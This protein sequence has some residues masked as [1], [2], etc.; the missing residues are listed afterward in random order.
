MLLEYWD[1]RNNETCLTHTILYLRHIGFSE[2]EIKDMVET[3]AY[4][5]LD[6]KKEEDNF[7]TNKEY[8]SKR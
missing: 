3:E 1:F 4:S 5:N 7:A 2:E 8:Y 6:F